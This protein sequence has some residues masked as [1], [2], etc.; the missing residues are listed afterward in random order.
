MKTL[1]LNKKQLA[2]MVA[3]WPMLYAYGEETSYAPMVEWLQQYLGF[4]V[5]E[6]EYRVGLYFCSSDSRWWEE[7]GWYAFSTDFTDFDWHTHQ[8]RD[9]RHRHL[10]SRLVSCVE[11]AG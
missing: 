11:A 9:E 6:V 3:R 1:N 7:K 10:A 8:D 5:K 4:T 2:R